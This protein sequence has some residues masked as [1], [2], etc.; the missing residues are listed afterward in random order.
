MTSPHDVY[1]LRAGEKRAF[2]WSMRSPIFSAGA[3]CR[4]RACLR[5]GGGGDAAAIGSC[6]GRHAATCRNLE[7]EKVLL[8][9]YVRKVEAGRPRR[10]VRA[11]TR[12]W[13]L[14]AA[15]AARVDVSV[16]PTPTRGLVDEMIE[17]NPDQATD[18]ELEDAAI[19]ILDRLYSRDLGG[20]DRS[21]R[22]TEAAPRNHGRVLLPRMPRPLVPSIS[23]SSILMRS[24]PAS[25]A[26][27]TAALPT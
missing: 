14:A 27:S 20:R 9:Q 19:P 24:F 21:L 8:Q 26:T 16:R 25:S 23:S 5:N 4:F 17:G 1:V 11:E 6:P 3:A 18:V 12:R 2:G 22:P 15:E 10:A 13:F 7:G